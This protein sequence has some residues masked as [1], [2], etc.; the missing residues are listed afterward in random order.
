[1]KIS[2]ASDP[3]AALAHEGPLVRGIVLLRLL[4]A[5]GR[6]GVAL[7]QLARSAGLP[8]STAHRLLQQLL[9]HRLA[10]QTEGSSRYVIGPLAYE[11]GLVAAHQFD[12]RQLCQPSMERLALDAADTVYLVQRSGT[13]AVC[14]DLRQ[15]P[16]TVQVTALQIGSRRPLGLGAG[17]LAILA[18]LPEDEAEEVLAAVTGVI[19]R[20]WRFPEQILRE[21][22]QA[23]RERRLA[24]IENRI[25]AG[26]TAIGRSFRD[27][28]GHV[29]GAITVAGSSA[30]MTRS[31]ASAIEGHLR[32]AAQ[33]IEHALRGHQWAQ[34]AAGSRSASRGR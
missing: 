25:T 10:M 13:E 34:Y 4:A 32:D 6:R 31:R 7:T 1:M 14:V 12:I 23:A 8:N 16:T 15:G 33:G 9:A 5:G 26:V 20:D 21:S 2:L 17:G 27:S 3:S 11:L 29:F 24:V 18:A 19:E 28:L 22:L 30:R